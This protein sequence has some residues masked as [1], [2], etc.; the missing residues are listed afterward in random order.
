VTDSMFRAV[1]CQGDDMVHAD[2]M[3]LRSRKKPNKHIY[4]HCTNVGLLLAP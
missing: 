1:I 4:T 2:R 3:L